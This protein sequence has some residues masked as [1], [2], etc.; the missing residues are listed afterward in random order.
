VSGL[1]DSALNHARTVVLALVF[2]IAAGISTYRAIPKEAQP[3][4]EIPFIYISMTHEGISPEDAERLL[5]RPMEQ[6]LRALEGVKEMTSSAYEGGANVTLEF[7]AGIDTDV[8]L[9]DVRAKVDLAKAEL[10]DETEEPTVNEV[11]ISRLDPMLVLNLSG[12]VP[13]RTL[14]VIARDLEEQIEA[15]PGVLDVEA[16]GKREE[17]MEVVVDPLAM[18]SYGLTQTELFNL[19]ARNNKL[20]AAGALETGQGRF[21][22]KVP[23]VFESAADVL[24]LPV[25]VD[26]DRVVHFRDIAEVRR[27]FKDATSYAR[28]DGEAAIALEVVQRAGANIILTIERVRAAVAEAQTMWPTGVTV[29]YSRDSSRDIENM[30]TDLQNNVISAVLLVL[31]V[32]I[33]ILGV[34]NALLVGIAIPGSFL[35]GILLI[36]VGGLTI[37]IVVL[38]SLIMA[39]GMLVDGA[40][41]VTELADRKMAEGLDPRAAYSEAA[42]RMAWPIIASTATTLAAF[43]PLVFWPGVTGEFMKY[44]PLTLIAVLSASLLMALVFVPTLGSLFGRTGALSV[45]AR[46]RLAA[47]EVGN[48]NS[49]GGFTEQYVH[50]LRR[51]LRRPL[52]TATGVTALLVLVFVAYGRFG[53]GVEFFP[54]VEPEFA[55]INIAARGDLSVD[56]KDALVRQVERRILDMPEFESIYARTGSG[57]R[58]SR[59]DQ[60]GSISLQLVDWDSRRPARDILAEVRERTADIAGVVIETKTPRAGPGGD[61]PLVIELSSRYPAAL[62]AAAAGVRG[63]MDQMDGLEDIE[64]SRPL[65]GIEWRIGVDRAKA[66]RFGA[67]VT[68]VGNT[69]QLVTNGVKIGEYRPDDADEEIDIRVRYPLGDRNLDEID[70]LR[71]PSASGPVPISNFV[72]R[73]P[74]QKVSTIERTDMRRTMTVSADVAPGVL[75][76]VKVRELR[77]GLQELTPDPR[78]SVS[79]R[80]DKEDQDEA[81]AFLSRAMLVAVFIIALILVTQFNSLFQAFLILTAVLFSTGGVL[82][83][84]L[85]MNMPFG[86]VMSGIGVIALAGIVVNNNIVLIDTY[87]YLRGHGMEYFEAV[88]RTCAQRLRPVLLTTVTT[89]LGLMPMVLG[90]NVNLVERQVT[91]GG[92]SSQWW[93]QLSASVAGGLAFA[94]VLTLVLTPALIVAQARGADRWQARRRRRARLAHDRELAARGTE[95]L[96]RGASQAP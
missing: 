34:R 12:K 51:A 72:T 55:R 92:P 95:D 39:V 50:F 4:I 30:L 20:V 94:T 79:F 31:I 9:Q 54:D 13:E 19:V 25:K 73:E 40:I 62:E 56:E 36:G 8:A 17:L 89:I 35:T 49:I 46:E 78:V 74:A 84:H 83:G 24:S 82:L 44:L 29:T 93:V 53:H 64:D 85:L 96:G 86:I 27:T 45:R 91:I 10:P 21:P 90:I 52:L 68:L 80:G 5:V 26:G 75:A 47:A 71:V 65:P 59:E 81:S 43:A 48:L 33:G 87:N 38:F 76:D 6:E 37:N 58:G 66:A 57:G 67:D 61:K 1:I 70:K 3:D 77:E 16:S 18:E 32:I 28:I 11:K 63:I 41:V 69:I 15:I 2:I 7:D 22:V 60:I 42:R 14:S 88:L 23:G